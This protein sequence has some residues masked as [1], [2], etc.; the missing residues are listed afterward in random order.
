MPESESP[1]TPLLDNDREL[2]REFRRRNTIWEMKSIAPEEE[3]THIQDGWTIHRRLKATIVPRG[4][5]YESMI[6]ARSTRDQL[7]TADNRTG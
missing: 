7:T 6:L 5:V 1:L 4:V 3:A 2:R